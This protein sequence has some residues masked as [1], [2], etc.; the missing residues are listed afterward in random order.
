LATIFDPYDNA[1]KASFIGT[2]VIAESIDFLDGRLLTTYGY[3]DFGT[4]GSVYLRDPG[5]HCEDNIR[6]YPHLL[7][8]CLTPRLPVDPFVYASV[9][10][11]DA[12]LPTT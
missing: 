3:L 10:P 6:V 5:F 12:P 9:H 7:S 4:R 2:L 11:D 1:T 8:Y